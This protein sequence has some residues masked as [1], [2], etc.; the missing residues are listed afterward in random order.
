MSSSGSVD[1]ASSTKDSIF[2]R[3][4]FSKEDPF[5][6][7]GFT[8]RYQAIGS[9]IVQKVE[10]VG[11]Y[12]ITH[13]HENTQYD[14]CVMRAYVNQSQ[15]LHTAQRSVCVQGSTATGSL[16]VALGSTFGAFLALG[17]IVLL[18]F[19][20][21]WQHSYKMSRQKQRLMSA[22]PAEDSG[23]GMEQMQQQMDDDG[24]IRLRGGGGSHDDIAMSELSGQ[25]SEMSIALDTLGRPK[26]DGEDERD[27]FRAVNSSLTSI[28][29]TNSLDNIAWNAA[30]SSIA[31]QMENSENGL[32]RPPPIPGVIIF[33]QPSTPTEYANTAFP[34]EKIEKPH[35]DICK[36][37]SCSNIRNK[38]EVG[39]DR[40]KSKPQSEMESILNTSNAV[41]TN[42]GQMADGYHIC[43][44][45][46]PT[47][48]RPKCD[49]DYED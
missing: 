16:A 11:A 31:T 28:H 33:H 20:A 32:L 30:I 46:S 13:L 27:P 39:L 23:V 41:N 44:Q 17:F 40:S 47:H 4:R 12:D 2:V 1:V 49:I 7:R 34:A 18:V 8:V 26:C 10:S 9:T 42:A 36:S 37:Y 5:A 14:I 25:S 24:S 38:S 15:V 43:A 6:T 22:T 3:W 48:N 29:D 35:P 45:T 21:K 19:V